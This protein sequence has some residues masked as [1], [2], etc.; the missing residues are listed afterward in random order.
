MTYRRLLLSLLTIFML[1]CFISCSQKMNSGGGEVVEPWRAAV[2]TLSFT[3]KHERIELNF[4]RLNF[5]DGN[6]FGVPSY[7]VFINTENNFSQAV[8]LGE[9][10]IEGDNNLG[11]AYIVKQADDSNSALNLVFSDIEDNRLYYIFVRSHF[12]NEDGSDT[13]KYGDYAVVSGKTQP[14]PSA[15]Q[16]VKVLKGDK[17]LYLSWDSIEG[18]EYGVNIDDCPKNARGM[19][20]LNFWSISGVKTPEANAVIYLSD[21]TATHQLCIASFN[22][23]GTGAWVIFDNMGNATTDTSKV[24]DQF[25]GWKGEAATIAPDDITLSLEALTS[26][27]NSVSVLYNEVNLNALGGDKSFA[28]HEI[29][30]EKVGDAPLC[31]PISFPYFPSRVSQVGLEEGV[32]YEVWL[33]AVNSVGTSSKPSNA[34]RIVTK[35]TEIDWSNPDFLLGKALGNFPFAEELPHSDFARIGNYKSNGG[36]SSDRLPRAKETALGNL[37]ADAIKSIAESRGVMLDF[38][39][40]KGEVFEGGIEQGQDITLR[41]LRGIT[42]SDYWVND[43]DSQL[44]LISL[45]GSDLINDEAISI[46]LN[47]Y[48]A[49]TSKTITDTLFG[50]IAGVNHRAHY[51]SG[52]VYSGAEWGIVSKGV[53]Y[54]IEYLPY[55]LDEMITNNEAFTTGACAEYVNKKNKEMYDYVADPL[56][57]YK[58]SFTEA[59]TKVGYVRG[60]VKNGTLKVGGADIDPNRTYNILTTEAIARTTYPALLKGQKSMEGLEGITLLRAVAE[61]VANKGAISPYKDGRVQ[62]EGGVPT[63][64]E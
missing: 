60:K 28:S 52:G 8:R 26:S 63:G 13:S 14:L 54:T 58:L 64:K 9:V 48:P 32:E 2:Q 46:D 38:A 61:Y 35:A 22:N 19:T 43:A 51:G 23:N 39:L 56:N 11:L 37:Y 33:K 3:G 10:L 21:N 42:K 55:D 49:T 30:T 5:G 16:N 20:E 24:S 44:V 15:V 45:K 7:E 50:Y 40:L 18:M 4:S 59:D 25:K 41:F 53:T 12:Y 17:H 1:S 47:N 31:T 57:C 34:P 29:C 36:R 62:L 27:K 6:P